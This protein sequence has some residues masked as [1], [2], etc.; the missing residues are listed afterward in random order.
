MNIVIVEVA[1]SEIQPKTIEW[2]NTLI[3]GCMIHTYAC[4]EPAARVMNM[5]RKS[6]G[7]LFVI[8]FTGTILLMSR[9]HWNSINERWRDIGILKSIG[10]TN[11]QVVSQIILES[12]LQSA[13][14]GLL[15]GLT[16]VMVL[17]A[18]PLK[19]ILGF[20]ILFSPRNNFCIL[21]VGLLLSLI[22]GLL[23]AACHRSGAQN[24]AETLRR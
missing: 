14:A 16:G 15:G 22:V 10:W 20:D 4:Y 8:I 19:E 9:T 13:I 5:G 7:F 1:S 21:L 2:V 17:V 18:L 3:H 23:S 24:P 6:I 12:M 11:G